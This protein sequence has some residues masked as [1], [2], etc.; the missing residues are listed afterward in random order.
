MA[1]LMALKAFLSMLIFLAEATEGTE[2]VFVS[3]G[4]VKSLSHTVSCD[5]CELRS[6]PRG[7]F[8]INGNFVNSEIEEEFGLKT[9]FSVTEDNV[10][11]AVVVTGLPLSDRLWIG[12]EI[13]CCDTY[14]TPIAKNW[15]IFILGITS[16][17]DVNL[18]NDAGVRVLSWS[19]PSFFSKDILQ[20]EKPV[21][22]IL[23]NGAS[24][25]NTTNTSVSLNNLSVI[26]NCSP[27][28]LIDIITS[29]G[30]YRSSKNE[31]FRNNVCI[32]NL[33]N[34]TKIYDLTEGKF[35]TNIIFQYLCSIKVC[36]AT[37]LISID[38]GNGT[39]SNDSFQVLP[40]NKKSVTV[41]QI[42]NGLKPG[43][44]TIEIACNSTKDI[45]NFTII[46]PSND[47]IIH[48]NSSLPHSF[49][50]TTISSVREGLDGIGSTSSNIVDTSPVT[51]S[52][53]GV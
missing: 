28:I 41:S 9:S 36:S 10:T 46:V 50:S 14:T 16:V 47:S 12:V 1:V 8:L 3:L 37:C 51:I 24:I 34:K 40:S 42:I 18:S 33:I 39:I 44:Y 17:E 5:G 35:S 4:T 20:K 38:Y 48:I 27:T 15:E 29:V 26:S 23:V 6:V 30:N 25:V 22:N 2:I 19:P 52:F 7:Y 21:Y 45:L 49:I 31:T 13:F 11:V 32:T 53:Y 43:S